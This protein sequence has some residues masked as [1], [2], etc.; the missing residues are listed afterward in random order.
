LEG[1]DRGGGRHTRLSSDFLVVV[2][3]GITLCFGGVVPI[4][5][6]ISDSCSDQNH[7]LSMTIN[8]SQHRDAT[9]C[10]NAKMPMTSKHQHLLFLLLT[11][12]R[13]RL[14]LLLL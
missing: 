10:A 7:R 13:K 4:A 11:I 6:N 5:M 14:K 2:F 8:A 12:L 1:W 3:I 9:E